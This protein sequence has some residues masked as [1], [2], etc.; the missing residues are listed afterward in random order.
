MDLDFPD[1]GTYG[2]DFTDTVLIKGG[3]NPDSVRVVQGYRIVWSNID[4]TA[5]SVVS[6]T[7]GIFDS[8]DISS[9]S[10]FEF[11]ATDFGTYRYHCGIHGDSGK[12]VV[13]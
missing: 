9:G 11:Y 5:H 1:P 13:E 2:F 4:A 8:G 6:D 7:P 3:F 12:I 10:T